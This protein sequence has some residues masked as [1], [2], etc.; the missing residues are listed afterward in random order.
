MPIP[1]RAP[2]GASSVVAADGDD[3]GECEWCSEV[4]QLWVIGVWTDYEVKMTDGEW[5]KESVDTWL[6]NRCA[7]GY[8]TAKE[9][10]ARA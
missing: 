4:G 2:S 10:E 7:E 9:R 1:A 6:C 5:R 3:E 8:L